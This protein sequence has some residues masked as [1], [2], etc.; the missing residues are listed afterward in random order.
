MLALDRGRQVAKLLV[1]STFIGVFAAQPAPAQLREY[2]HK[3]AQPVAGA[4]NPPPAADTSKVQLETVRIPTNGTDPIAV[5]NNEVITR[6]QLAD[7][8]VARKGQEILDTLIARRLIEQEMK[9]KK[10]EITPKEIDEEIDRVAMGVGHVSREVWLRTLEKERGVSPAAYARD[11]IY[12][13]LA[14]R[15][16]A[17][18]RVQVTEQDLKDAFEAN[19][20]PRLRCRMIMTNDI[21]KA[22]EIW[23]EA[24]KNPAGFEKLAQEKSLDNATRPFGG[25]LPEPI[26]RHAVPREVSDAA[27]AQLIDGDPNDKNPAHKPKDGDITG[28]IQINEGAWVIM[29]REAIAPGRSGSLADKQVRDMLEVQMFDVKLK[30]SMNKIYEGLML[31]AKIENKLTGQYKEGHEEDS[32]EYKAALTD[33]QLMNVAGETKPSTLPSTT[34]A[35]APG[36]TTPI[37]ASSRPPAGVPSGAAETTQAVG[38]VDT[39]RAA[40]NRQKNAPR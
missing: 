33:K 13:S 15:K 20:G 4:N 30:D 22:S 23:E 9:K 2:L 17:E 37:G 1:T 8:C 10:L 31:A 12:P 26:A 6:Q 5:V 16:L 34:R 35:V 39:S 7:E 29:K 38:S 18:P 3:K 25:L 11:I 19:F 21:R 27:F 36:S 14:L 32:P 24:R 28:P 40:Q